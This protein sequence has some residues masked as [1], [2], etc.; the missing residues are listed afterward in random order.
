MRF[1]LATNLA[2]TD[3][4]I[5][6]WANFE[7]ERAVPSEASHKMRWVL[8]AGFARVA[9]PTEALHGSNYLMVGRVLLSCPFDKAAWREKSDIMRSFW[10]RPCWGSSVQIL[11]L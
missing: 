5:L 4:K 9:L 8:V 6:Q 7:A 11:K 10:N 2:V 1:A 3:V